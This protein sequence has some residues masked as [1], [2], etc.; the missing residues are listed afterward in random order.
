[1]SD[2][3]ATPG[4]VTGPVW[5]VVV[6]GGTGRRFGAAKQYEPLAGRTVLE[7]AVAVADRTCDG[8]VVVVPIEHLERDVERL[9]PPADVVVAGGVSRAASVR[10]GLAAVPASAGV[11]LVHDAARP[12]ATAELFRRVVDAVR[13]GAD[14]A[15]PVVAVTDT[16]REVGGGVIDRARLR[17]VQ[18]PQGF[19]TEVLRAAHADAVDATD[20]AALVER[21]GGTV[22]LVAGEPTNIKITGPQDCAIA[23]A[24]LA[25]RGGADGGSSP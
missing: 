9:V 1:M 16:I 12:L 10:S 2:D 24:V 7:H 19:R 4:S 18:T 25:E 8:V 6:A 22:T 17:A 23:H 21:S 3:Q 15:V 5:C 14:A 13:N 20:D 11:V